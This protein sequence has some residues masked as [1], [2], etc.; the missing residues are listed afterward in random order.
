MDLPRISYGPLQNATDRFADE[1]IAPRIG[2]IGLYF[3]PQ[4]LS[5]SV[6]SRSLADLVRSVNVFTDVFLPRKC[7]GCN[8][9]HKDIQ[10]GYTDK[11]SYLIFPWRPHRNMASVAEATRTIGWPYR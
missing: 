6:R 11:S 5:V 1:K 2:P 9:C 7:Q 3:K 4:T 10:D 8:G